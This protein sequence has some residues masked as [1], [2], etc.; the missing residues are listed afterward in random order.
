MPLYRLVLA[1]CIVSASPAMAQQAAIPSLDFAFFKA[2]G[3]FVVAGP[4]AEKTS[5]TSNYP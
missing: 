4:I 3:R 2:R 1:A 5:L